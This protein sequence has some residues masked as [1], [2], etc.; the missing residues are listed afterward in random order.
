[1]LSQVTNSVLAN[2]NLHKF[3]VDT[4]GVFKIDRNL[5][6]QIGI[7]T[8]NLNPKKIHIYGNGGHLLPE[9]NGDFRYED[10]Q[11][12]A[13]YIEGEEDNSFDSNDFIL[14]YAKGTHD[15]NVNPITGAV[16]HNQNIYSD[17]AYYFITVNEVDGKRIQNQT[18]ITGPPT[19]QLTSFND[20]VFY[21][22]EIINIFAAGR[23]WL[24]EEFSIENQQTFQI[25]FPNVLQSEPLTI[26]GRVVGVSSSAS[27]MQVSVNS[28]NI[29]T[30]NFNAIT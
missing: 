23:R 8:N 18:P 24:G 15:W 29:S 2:G 14:F 3:S 12:N 1:M 25:P 5:L 16:S 7:T 27:S 11:E 19:I 10:L 28:Q 13:I 21:E 4:T 30:V 22:K 20:Y 9:F 6:Q 17:E 26:S